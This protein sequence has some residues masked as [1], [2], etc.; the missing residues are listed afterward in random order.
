MIGLIISSSKIM[1][2]KEANSLAL[3]I[4]NIKWK[5][6]P[7]CTVSSNTLWMSCITLLT[8]CIVKISHLSYLVVIVHSTKILT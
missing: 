7:V 2:W 1:V 6:C 8:K 4:S 5:Q 3:E